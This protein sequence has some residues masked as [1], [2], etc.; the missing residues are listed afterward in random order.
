VKLE[1]TKEIQVGGVAYKIVVEPDR[2][3]VPCVSLCAD[4]AEHL[5]E[6]IMS[7]S[8]AARAFAQVKRQADQGGDE[9]SK[10]HVLRDATIAMSVIPGKVL[11]LR[12]GSPPVSYGHEP[13]CTRC[14]ETIRLGVV[15]YTDGDGFRH[16]DSAPDCKP[17][18]RDT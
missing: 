4:Q 15:R 11:D 12:S 10:E 9:V 18:V 13:E 16:V 6:L 7:A 2:V 14:G 3:S 17:W 5:A 1:I 8:E